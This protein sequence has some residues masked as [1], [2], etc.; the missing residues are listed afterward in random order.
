MES[1][2]SEAGDCERRVLRA[3]TERAA[4]EPLCIRPGRSQVE[5]FAPATVPH[6]AGGDGRFPIP[7]LDELAEFSSH[8][9][10]RVGRTRRQVREAI[11]T[12]RRAEEAAGARARCPRG[13][14]R[15]VRCSCCC[16]RRRSFVFSPT[17]SWFAPQSPLLSSSSLDSIGG[18][19][20]E[21]RPPRSGGRGAATAGDTGRGPN[22]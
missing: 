18:P 8:T 13:K 11:R 2:G 21:R 4:H 15:L 6:V 7:S 17:A 19:R 12:E 9:P 1:L 20:N 3:Q 14:G 16:V 5:V 10:C 22:E